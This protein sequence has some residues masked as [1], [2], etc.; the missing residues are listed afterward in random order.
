[1]LAFSA[2]SMKDRSKNNSIY[3]HVKK[4]AEIDRTKNRVED[5]VGRWRKSGNRYVRSEIMSTK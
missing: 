3:F 2:A 1:M 5:G 4:S